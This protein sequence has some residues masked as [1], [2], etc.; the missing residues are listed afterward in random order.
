MKSD[1]LLYNQFHNGDGDAATE[2]VERYGDSITVYIAGFIGNNFDAEDLMIEAFSLMFAKKRSVDKDG[3]FKAY[4]YKIARN[5]AIKYSRKKKH[6]LGFSELNFEP[7]SDF[8]TDMPLIRTERWRML[9]SAMGKLKKEYREALF[10][11][12]FEELS[13]RGAANIMGKSEEQITKLVYR[14]KQSLKTALE[15]E[16]FTY[17]ND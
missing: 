1:E 9:Y 14:G 6:I 17:E 12:Y 10:L 2:L 5:L 15:R 7:K 8:L 4:I 16:G 3:S 13:Y 11:V